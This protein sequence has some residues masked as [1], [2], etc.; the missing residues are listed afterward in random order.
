MSLA[1][2]R[3]YEAGPHTVEVIGTRRGDEKLRAGWAADIF[4]HLQRPEVY[5][6]EVGLAHRM[7]LPGFLVAYDSDSQKTHAALAF[8]EWLGD[9]DEGSEHPGPVVFREMGVTW[10]PTTDAYREGRGGRGVAPEKYVVAAGSI[11]LDR[12]LNSGFVLLEAYPDDTRGSDFWVHD[13]KLQRVPSLGADAPTLYV[14]SGEKLAEDMH[15]LLN[16]DPVQQG[17]FLRHPDF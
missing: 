14:A 7:R 4:P 5:G 2:G 10:G 9:V 16:I 6:S 1:K 13:V 17:T 11:L 15:N 8:G 3:Q 12:A